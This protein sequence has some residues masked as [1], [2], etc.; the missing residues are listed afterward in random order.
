M[1]AHPTYVMAC[2]S[3]CSACTVALGYLVDRR[4]H[5]LSPLA[6]RDQ[7]EAQAWYHNPHIFPTVRNAT[8]VQ[9]AMSFVE[10]SFVGMMALMQLRFLPGTD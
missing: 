8:F 4:R 10:D 7:L 6:R 3:H 9:P 5:H 2:G 1:S